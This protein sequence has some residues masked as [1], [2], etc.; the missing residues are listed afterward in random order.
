LG[1]C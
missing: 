1:W